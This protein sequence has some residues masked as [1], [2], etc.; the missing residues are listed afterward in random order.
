VV[1]PEALKEDRMEDTAKVWHGIMA[2]KTP[3]ASRTYPARR[4]C[5]ER[6][7]TTQLSIYNARE[8]CWQHEP[9][10]SFVLRAP[11]KSRHAAA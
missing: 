5:A 2:G 3:A 6:S 7:C 11:R 10:R 1:E 8:F 4:V 9:K